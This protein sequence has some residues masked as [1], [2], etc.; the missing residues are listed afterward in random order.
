MS[1]PYRLVE[2]VTTKLHS[3]VGHNPYAIHAIA[4]HHAFETLFPPD[5]SQSF[6]YAHLVFCSATR[7]DLQQDF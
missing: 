2:I 3:A 5:L 1:F 6:G 7:L 4:S